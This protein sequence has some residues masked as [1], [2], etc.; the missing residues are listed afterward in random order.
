MMIDL[1][2]KSDQRAFTLVEVIV[3]ILATAI[4]GV[5]FTSF[6][7]TAMS[8]SVRSVEIVRGEAD[9]EALLEQIVA[10]YVYELNRDPAALNTMKGYI[11]LPTRKYGASVTADYI[12]FDPNTG[13]E[14]PYGGAD[15]NLKRTLKVTVAAAGNDL[16]TLLT[17]SRSANSPPV[18]F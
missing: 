14:T 4:L 16:V 8:K 9:A 11:D 7:G 17:R 15:E 18:P 1:A 3:T 6:M 12:V 10:D 13:N 5:I 2:G